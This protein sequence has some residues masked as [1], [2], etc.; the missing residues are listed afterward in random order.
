MSPAIPSIP[1]DQMPVTRASCRD[2]HTKQFRIILACVTIITVLACSAISY[3]FF[4]SRTIN[5]EVARSRS[6]DTEH[7]AKINSN[8]VRVRDLKADITIQMSRIEDKLDKTQVILM[9]LKRDG[10]G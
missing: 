10:G 4:Q 7:T 5:S 8:E 6:L 3:A 9:E 1:E 2:T